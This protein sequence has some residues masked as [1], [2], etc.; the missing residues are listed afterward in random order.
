WFPTGMRGTGSRTMSVNEVFVPD[1][2]VQKT[3]DTVQKLKE[4]RSLHPTFDAMYATWP[5]HGRFPFAACAVGAGL[6]AAEHFIATA[7][8]STR[9][10]N[11][12]GGTI[13]LI[14]QDYVATDFAQAYSDLQMAK[15]LVE[16]RSRRASQRAA[17]RIETSP[18][19]VSIDHLANAHVTRTALQAAQKIF[20]I[21][22][23][24]AG[25]PSHPVSIAKRDI[26]VISHHV[27]L[28]W[29]QAA[30]TF[31]K[32]VAADHGA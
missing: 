19:E 27:T 5:S 1:R 8:K 3:S 30:S 6:G 26:E 20:S 29:R 16:D 12:I 28:N 22:G 13:K 11:D 21:I 9:V 2:R 10:A 14:D 31:L 17:E 7:G 18:R 32:T 23:S 4:R 15:L 24:K 25:S